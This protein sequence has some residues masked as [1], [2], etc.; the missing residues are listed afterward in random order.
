MHSYDVYTGKVVNFSNKVNE[1]FPL[2]P[3]SNE[4]ADLILVEDLYKDDR[5]KSAVDKAAKHLQCCLYWLSSLLVPPFLL[6]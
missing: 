6:E 5:V 2:L 4:M 3:R 1:L